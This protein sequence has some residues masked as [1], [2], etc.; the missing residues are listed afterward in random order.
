MWGTFE[1]SKRLG[2][3][4]GTRKHPAQK[5]YHSRSRIEFFGGVLL[6][7]FWEDVVPKCV[8]VSMC[9]ASVVLHR[10]CLDYRTPRT[11]IIRSKRC[12]V[13][14]N[15][16]FANLGKVRK[17]GPPDTHFDVILETFGRQSLTLL[18]FVGCL[19]FIRSFSESGT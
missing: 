7:P 17:S 3:K 9:L 14:Q 6:G 19:F 4:N 10:K 11:P 5:R 8:F 15:Q 2:D 18:C 16:G 13:I 12:R 1:G